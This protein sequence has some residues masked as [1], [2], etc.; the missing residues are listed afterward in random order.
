MNKAQQSI[1]AE[2]SSGNGRATK[3]APHESPTAASTVPLPD[4]GGWAGGSQ[5]QYR[6]LL[7]ASPVAIG[8]PD[9]VAGRGA[10][11]R[12]H[13][14]AYGRQQ[15]AAVHRRDEVP[16]NR[17][18]RNLG[19]PQ[20]VDVT[21]QAGVGDAGFGLGVAVGNYDN[22]GDPDLY[23]SNFGPN[24][25]LS[26]SEETGTVP[27][28]RTGTSGY[29]SAAD[30]TKVG[31]SDSFLDMDGDGDLDLFVA[32]YVK[33][34]FDNKSFSHA[35]GSAD[36]SGPRTLSAVIRPCCTATGATERLPT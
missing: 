1:S 20:F 15:R 5:S 8:R 17:L 31:A 3:A 7:P 28:S 10:A 9:P 32:N 34:S 33:F 36:L 14:P 18:Y 25:F 4:P 6:R 24:V 11:D 29:G 27:R 13:V 26:Q 12:N 23:V 35:A 2:P 22:D 30:E 21:D 19:G 16:R